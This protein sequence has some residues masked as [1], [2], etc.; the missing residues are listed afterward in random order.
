MLCNYELSLLLFF[1]VVST[2]LSFI[3]F[4]ISLTVLSLVFTFSFE[5]HEL[6]PC[7]NVCLF[8][9]WGGLHLLFEDIFRGFVFNENPVYSWLR[10]WFLQ[11]PLPGLRCFTACLF[12]L[13]TVL[14][15]PHPLDLDTHLKLGVVTHCPLIA[16]K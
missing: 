14:Q 5:Q 15:V 16:P 8:V 7:L 12:V 6:S 11:S 10:K 9:F 2:I 13:S 3:S 4:I 1:V